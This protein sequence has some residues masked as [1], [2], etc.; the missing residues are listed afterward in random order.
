[1]LRSRPFGDATQPLFP[2]EPLGLELSLE[3]E[4]EPRADATN[5]LGGVGDVLEAKG[6]RGALPHL[7]DLEE[8]ALC[9]ND[10]QL[11]VVPYRWDKGPVEQYTVRVWVRQE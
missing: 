11:Q 9:G 10:R 6:G 8:V 7:A 5:F 1:M 4:H 2:V 3:S